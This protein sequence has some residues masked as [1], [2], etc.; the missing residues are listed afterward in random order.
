MAYKR[1]NVW[2]EDTEAFS[3]S[4]TE[5]ILDKCRL[6]VVGETATH[7][8][9]YC[10][11]HG[12]TD[13]PA[14]ALSKT[15]GVYNCFNPAC[16]AA[17]GIRRLIAHQQP[18]L[19]PF[20]IERLIINSKHDNVTP[21]A[22]R[23]KAVMAE[24]P[25]FVEFP[26]EQLTKLKLALPGS[27]A[28]RYMIE[29]RGFT[30]ETLDYFD[31]GYSVNQNMVIVPMHD[32]KGNPIGLIGRTP[33]KTDKRFKNSTNLPKSKTVWNF[34]RA[35]KHDTLIVTEASYDSM[36]VHQA[37]Y[38]GTGA[39]LGGSI[40][41]WHKQQIDRTFSTIIIMT[42]FDK[43]LPP[44]SNCS[45]CKDREPDEFGI[46]CVG[47]RPG[48]ELGRSIVRAFPHKK[49]LWAAYDDTCVYP[50][51]AKDVGDLTDAEIRQCIKNAVSNIDYVFWEIEDQDLL[52][53][54]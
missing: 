12:N 52:T 15:K 35:K 50:H 5:S 42:D 32:P 25:E 24:E 18:K 38:P 13:S 11:F 10:P 36:R 9:M 39:L 45:L 19:N 26:Q 47:H 14:L 37:G 22:D 54:S 53:Q 21:F 4:Q 49:I 8:L 41:E 43:R 51:G 29:E 46:R 6:D 17:G 27:I 23:L 30:T 7:F 31:V 2:E 33:S 3:E 44:K 34:H 48:R 20:Q 40:S 1:N 28:E 16:G